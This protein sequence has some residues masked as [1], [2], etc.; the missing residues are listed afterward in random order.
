VG[1][2][3]TNLWPIWAANPFTIAGFARH[4][5]PAAVRLPR[6]DV[7]AVT[8]VLL[9]GAPFTDWRLD[10]SWLART[11]GL[12]W[13]VCRDRVSVSYQFGRPPPDGGRVACITLATEL[14]RFA[15]PE[16]DQPCQLPRRLASVTR[17]G[18]TYAALDDMKFLDD[19]LTGLYSVD[20]WLRSVNPKG[21]SQAARCW[22]PDIPMGT[23]R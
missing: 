2:D 11:D 19:G 4:F 14:G 3:T 23:R 1:F 21:R 10:G 8:E 6:S 22:S 5:E 20:S 12:T 15:S 18:L 16:P 7:T 17:Q 13:P 9:D